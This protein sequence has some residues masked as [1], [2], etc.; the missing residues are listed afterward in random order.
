MVS[1]KDARVKTEE[2]KKGKKGEGE[3]SFKMLNIK[4]QIYRK[5]NKGKN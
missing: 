1:I 2:K 3:M 4:A 5:G